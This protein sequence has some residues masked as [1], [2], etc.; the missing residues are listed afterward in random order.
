F[1]L[2]QGYRFLGIDRTAVRRQIEKAQRAQSLMGDLPPAVLSGEQQAPQVPSKRH[3]PEGYR[4]AATQA[5]SVPSP[6]AQR[7]EE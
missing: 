5:P 3:F 4:K 6:D 1:T 7:G 2:P